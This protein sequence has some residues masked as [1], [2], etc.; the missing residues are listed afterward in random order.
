MSTQPPPPPSG[1]FGNYGGPPPGGPA[2]GFGYGQPAM[3]PVNNNMTMAILVTI[4]CCLPLGIVAIVQAASV[5]KKLAMGDYNGAV[6]AAKQ[7]KTWAT[8]GIVAGL[9]VAVFWFLAAVA[10]SAGSSY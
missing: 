1:G 7:A 8:V 2:G 10:G 9:V 5:N 3:G 6:N 4:F